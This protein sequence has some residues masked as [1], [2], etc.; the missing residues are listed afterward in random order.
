MPPPYLLIATI[1][2]ADQDALNTAMGK[3]G[4]VIID[5]V[6]NFTNIRPQILVGELLMS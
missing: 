6:A 3:K 4:G 1:T 5:D 2:F